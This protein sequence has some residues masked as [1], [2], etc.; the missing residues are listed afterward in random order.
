MI[1]ALALAATDLHLGT[2]TPTRSPRRARRRTGLVALERSGIGEGALLP[3]EML[4]RRRTDPAPVAAAQRGSTAST[5]PSRPGPDWRRDGTAIVDAFPVPTAAT[6]RAATRSR[7]CA[8]PPTRPAPD[9]RVGGQPAANAD[10]IDAVYGSF[11]LMIAL[12]AI[13]TFILLA[14]AFRSLLLP[15]K[16]ILLNILS[17]GAAWGVLAL[18]WQYGLRLGADLGHRTQPARS[19]PGCR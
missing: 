5:A 14:R 8:T 19:R 6:T 3:H 9:V 12:I 4:D 13:T 16:A 1:L 17:V 15:L 11:P 18:V 2:P 10:F 7:A